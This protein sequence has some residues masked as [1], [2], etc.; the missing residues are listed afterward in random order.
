[1]PDPLTHP[2]PSPDRA[3][4]LLIDIQ[5]RLYPAMPPGVAASVERNARILVQTA[6]EFSLPVLVTEQYPKGLGRTLP[7]LAAELP[8]GV[9]PFEKVDFDCCA[10]PGFTGLLESLG[11]RDWIVSGIETHVCVLQ[12]VLS[13]LAAGRRVFVAADATCSRVKLNW[14]LGLDLMRRFGAVIGSTEIFA[15]GLTKAAGTDQFRRISRLV[16]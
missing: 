7:A 3:A 10:A 12:S 6:C 14:K 16:K 15:F 11:D 4:L 5:E 8:P 9:T 1:M 13:M 2:L